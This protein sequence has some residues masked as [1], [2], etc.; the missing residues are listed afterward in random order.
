[1]AYSRTGEIRPDVE[2]ELGDMSSSSPKMQAF[3]DE[4][5]KVRDQLSRIRS[6]TNELRRAYDDQAYSGDGGSSDAV[7]RLIEQTNA[8]CNDVRNR[9]K[10]LT[11]E[12]KSLTGGDADTRTR[13]NLTTNLS[14]KFM[15]MIQ[16]FQ[17]IQ[18]GCKDRYRDRIHR[19]AKIVNPGI[20]DYEVDHMLESGDPQQMFAASLIDD[21]KQNEAKNALIFIQEQHRDVVKLEKSIVELHQLFIDMQAL[22]DLQGEMIS[23]IEHNVRQAQNYTSDGVEVL[24]M[25]DHTKQASRKKSCI[26]CCI[27]FIILII[28]IAIILAAIGI[29]VGV[30]YYKTKG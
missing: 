25:A 12:N 19:Q 18:S 4:V 26:L 20:S 29:G 16:E 30:A 7:E 15:D 17:D 13:K 6:N 3:Y 10:R 14:K 27:L 2:I 22:V 28:I 1:M 8:A 5:S 11:N 23:Q 9:L 24:V 21:R